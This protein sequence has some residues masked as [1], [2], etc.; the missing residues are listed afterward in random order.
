[1]ILS[2][3]FIGATALTPQ[4]APA[5]EIAPA[6]VATAGET[7]PTADADG[8]IETERD[9]YSVEHF[10]LP[11]GCVME[12]GG[13]DMDSRGRLFVSTRRGQVW[14][15]ENPLADDL[16]DADVKLYH[17]GLWEGLG[18][19]IVDDRVYVVQRGELSRLDD[20]DGDDRCDRVVTIA[21][22]WGVSGHY[23]EFAFGLPRESDGHWFVGLNV[24]F[25]DPEWWHGRSTVPY[26][27][28]VM[29]VSPDGDVEPWAVGVRSPNG[30]CVDSQD[31]VFVTDNQG[32]WI[33]SSPIYRIVK[34]GFY[35]H[36]K[37]LN[38]TEEYRAAGRVAHDEI[39]PAEAATERVPPA[40]WIPY[41]WSRSTGNL[42]EDRSG[43]AFGVPEGQF[44]VAEL[45][46]G[47][48]LRAGFE[49]VQGVTQGWV[50]PLVQEIGSVNRVFQAPDGTVFC[51]LT[52]R[53]WGGL[54]PADG[55]A[56]VRFKGETPMEVDS[57]AILDLPGEPSDSDADEFGFEVTFRRPVAEGWTPGAETV[58]MIQYDYDYWWEYGSPE[59]HTE[60]LE[61]ASATLSEDRTTLRA[62]FAGM[63]PARCVRLTLKGVEAADGADL[64]HPTIS[65]TVN[66]LPS[67][68]TTNAY[69]AKLVPPPP[70]KNDKATGVLHLSWGDATEQ[71]EGEGW[72][73]V[74]ASLPSDSAT[75]F[76][77]APGSGA[78]VRTANGPGA[79]A[80]RADLGDLQLSFDFMVPS[81]GE[82]ALVLGDGA[83]RITLVDDA[84][85]CGA[86]NGAAPKASGYVGPGQWA[87]VVV[88]YMT[89][90]DGT[91]QVQRI[92]VGGVT[93]FDAVTLEDTVPPRAPFRFESEKGQLAL[94]DIRV[95][96]LD[97]ADEGDAPW[98]FLDPAE[99]WDAWELWGDATF[100]LTG[101]GLK[102]RGAL[103]HLWS[104]ETELEDFSVRFRAKVNSN[105]A[106]ALVLRAQE[107]ADGEIEGYAVR[108]NS[109]FP[110][111]AFTGSIT[112]G[113]E[114]APVRATMVAA[115]TWVEGEAKVE[116]QEDGSVRVTVLLGGV[117]VNELVDP[118]PLPAG[119]LAIRND[120]EGTVLLVDDLRLQE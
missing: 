83:A 15:V 84:E 53:G 28:W 55:L 54:A 96:P 23:H 36:P 35:G 94:R 39:P 25:G 49:D 67:G 75:A 5:E 16:A 104:P 80:S 89:A 12:V 47:M 71:F 56:R 58:S 32:D 113:G 69:V 106:G 21:D 109:S 7:A 17:E 74:D 81:G 98:R 64:L 42:L 8:P 114:S 11:D 44:V 38:W 103:G 43:G 93:A 59:R 91:A 4:E 63:L 76:E 108:I 105:G 6:P 99:D 51:G 57:M 88:W 45:T 78:I 85:R 13:M 79:F 14:I 92:D 86:L 87:K 110:D 65:Y 61:L 18:L 112:G 115:D 40:I 9:A 90:D 66:Q 62:R 82:G 20:T 97:Q 19:D 119:G 118:T 60:A 116:T 100:D 31:R 111:D 117:V 33:A 37:S 1:M 30:V 73:A 107:N 22:D 34:D 120:H 102:S 26:R 52:N 41:E 77:L 29:R 72:E 48:I 46:N 101:E 68:A 50:T 27:G 10:Q 2:T 3:L 95:K 24:S 70:S